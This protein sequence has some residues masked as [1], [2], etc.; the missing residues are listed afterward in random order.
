TL[1]SVAGCDSIITTNLTVL[2]PV[3]FTEYKSICEGANY[4]GWTITRKYERTLIAMLGRDSIVTTYLTVNP[5]YSITEIV[6]IN[7]GEAYQTWTKSG[8][9]SRALISVAGCDS[10]VITNL[11]V[12]APVITPKQVIVP[13]LF[14]EYK[15]ICDG[16]SY[17]G[18]TFT[19]KFE[20]TLTTS[21]G[22]DSIVTTYLTVNPKY[23]VTESITITE[24]E[25]Y[26]TW[27]KSG[28]YSRSLISVAGCDSTVFTYLTVTPTPE[29]TQT[30]QLTKGANLF[31]ANLI[32]SNPDL[33]VVLKSLCDQGALINVLNETGSSFEYVASSGGWVNKIGSI[34]K[35]E[36]YSINLNF[37][38][39]LKITGKLVPLP[40]DIPLKKGWNFISYPRMDVVNAMSIIQTLITQNK[41]VKVQDE[42]GYTIEKVKGVWKNS[43]GNFIPGKGY[44]INVS[45]D[46]ILSI[47][48]TYTKSSASTPQPEETEYF[49]GNYSGNGSNHMNIYIGGLTQAGISEGDELAAFDRNICVGVAKITKDHITNGIANLIASFSTNGTGQDGFFE[50]NTLQ[51]YAW[52]QQTGNESKVNVDVVDGQMSYQKMASVLLNMKSSATGLINFGDAVKIDVFPNPS[53]GK[54]TVR[55]S[56]VPVS[57]SRIDILD[58]SGRKIVSRLISGISEEFNLDNQPAGLYLVKSILGSEEIIQ[59]LIIK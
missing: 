50:G 58:L 59:K 38:A 45:N 24:G 55:Y 18:W 2:T 40:M 1:S 26:K 14:T 57:G 33:G 6:S 47:Q 32:P 43:I 27:T 51:V 34:S 5:K 29:Y 37:D 39:Q 48:S 9:Y 56:Q 31:S 23:N 15:S 20:R 53:V 36:G 16:N 12:I 30:I 28:Q 4:N 8:Q 25:V 19:G 46:A 42:K 52:N 7:E 13:V 21:L 35:T 54:V 10:I 17:N 44:K 3:L 22:G 11:Q 41:L 49:V